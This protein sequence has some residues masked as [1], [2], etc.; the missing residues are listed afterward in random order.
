MELRYQPRLVDGLLA[1][2]LQHH[3]AAMLVGPRAT[4]KTTTATRQA[5]SILR[6]DEPR[7][8][9]AVEADPDVALRDLPEPIL[10][11]EWQIVPEVLGAV[12]RAVDSEPRPGRFIITGSVR[13]DLDSPTWPGTGRLLRIT[14]TGLTVAEIRGAI[15]PV[16]LLDRL[17]V[18]GCEAL[19][20][21]TP[22]HLDLRDY[23]D[24][25]ATGGFPQPALRLPAPERPAWLESY[26]DQLLTRDLAEIGSHR[27]PQLLRRYLEAY[28]LNTAGVADHR[29]IYE[30]AG[31]A[32]NTGEAYE[33]LLRN[34]LVVDALPAWWSN[35]I[36]RLM[37]GPK[38]Y[39]VDSSL[40]LAIIRT[41]IG[42]LMRDGDLLGRLV[43][44]FVT[45]QLRAQL[46]VCDS[47]P[48][49]F[50]LRQE[51]GQHEADLI[52]EYGGGRIFAFEIKAASAPRK[53]AAR[54]LIWLRDELGDRFIGGAVLH[55]GPRSFMFDERVAAAPI[56]ALWA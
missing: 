47:Q 46:A 39:I 27:N 14:M 32:R 22:E 43:D 31:I 7:Q 52:V 18:D 35:R 3:P 15:P 37:R 42:G 55:T 48:R 26:V 33:Q 1:N 54:H 34:L 21:M 13:G 11:D 29:S 30:A 24:L 38:R 16:P 36:K 2:R 53:E 19:T 9:V 10:I 50:H 5:R 28:A 23:A 12:K 20:D 51:K 4:G 8:S 44:T 17:V 49:L 41:D 45:A 40:A 25:A 56:S 6:L